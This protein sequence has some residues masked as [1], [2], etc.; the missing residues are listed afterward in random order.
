MNKLTKDK[1]RRS[2]TSLY[3]YT[4]KV[5]FRSHSFIMY[6]VLQFTIRYYMMHFLHLMNGLDLKYIVLFYYND[7]LKIT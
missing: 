4:D 7:F 6:N 2:K 1:K 3:P 5:Y